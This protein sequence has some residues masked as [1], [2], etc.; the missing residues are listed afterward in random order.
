MNCKNCQTELEEGVTLCPN[1]GTENAEAKADLGAGKIALLVVLAVAAIAVIVALVMGS[2]SGSTP[3]ETTLPTEPVTS[4]TPTGT[5]PAPT[6]PA[7]GNPDDVTCKGSYTVTD[8]QIAASAATVVATV[9]DKSLTNAELQ[10][11]YWMQVIDFLN[12]YYSYAS[13]FGLD[14]TQDLDTQ[15]CMDGSMTWQQYFLDGALNNW[16][17]YQ[18]MCLEADANGFVLDQEYTDYL[19]ELPLNLEE[20]AVSMGFENAAAMIQA[21][22]G[23]GATLEGYMTYLNDYYKG[24]MYYGAALEAMEVTDAEVEAYFDEHA[25]EYLENGLEKTDERYV[26]VRHILISPTSATGE[27]TYTE[28]EWAAAEARANEILN[29][30]LTKNPDEDGFSVLA[31]AYSVDTGSASNGG[32]YQNV[33]VGQMVEPFENWCFEEGRQ[34]GDYGIVK[35]DFGYHIMYFVSSNLVWYLTAQQDMMADLGNTFLQ[36]SLEKYPAEI[37]Y[38]AIALGYV[39]LGVTAE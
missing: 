9:G 17:N 5:T 14:V 39:N 21:D 36:E 27:S 10:V 37:D 1:C 12:Q 4:S 20:S 18:A 2:G 13:L 33:Y 26:D 25:A 11:Y 7:D 23:P 3:A 30:W 29:E 28:E 35:T 34:Y 16:H 8:D 22:M 31:Q 15:I 24:Y 38:S 32:L 19:E 6:I